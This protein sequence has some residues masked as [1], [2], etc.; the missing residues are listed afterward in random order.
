MIIVPTDTYYG[1]SC[2]AFDSIAVDKIF[3][4][5]RREKNQLLPVLISDKNEL[6]KL[7]IKNTKTLNFLTDN[8]WP[9]PLTIILKTEKN[10]NTLI[11]F[12][13]QQHHKAERGDNERRNNEKSSTINLF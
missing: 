1:I 9:G 10:L 2:D 5:K 12:R 8:F 6:Q 13:Y 3:K 7:G 11:D 4:I